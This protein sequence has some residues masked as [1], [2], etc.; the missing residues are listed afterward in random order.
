M[1]ILFILPIHNTKLLVFNHC[2]Q[3]GLKRRRCRDNT[4]HFLLHYI[5]HYFSALRHIA[6]ASD[7]PVVAAH[8]VSTD[9]LNCS[10]VRSKGLMQVFC[11]VP[12]QVSFILVKRCFYWVCLA[13]TPTGTPA[14]HRAAP[15]R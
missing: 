4:H 6:Y 3:L 14:M 15:P 1:S 7:L 9:T 10:H 8:V 13:S 12:P 5:I 11:V 2:E